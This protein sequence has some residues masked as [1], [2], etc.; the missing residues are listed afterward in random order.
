MLARQ[1]DSF[2]CGF[3]IAPRKAHR[4]PIK[5]PSSNVQKKIKPSLGMKTVAGSKVLET[6]LSEGVYHIADF[7][8]SRGSLGSMLVDIR[9]MGYEV[10]CIKS[11][12][13]AVSYELV[14]K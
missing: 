1:L 7:G 3:R 14:R 11:G 9:D 13:Y 5:R 12:R 6:L 4:Q 10:R 8:G 2:S